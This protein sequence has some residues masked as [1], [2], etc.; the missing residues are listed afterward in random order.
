MNTKSF[1]FY[2]KSIVIVLSFLFLGMTKSLAGVTVS[3]AAPKVC[4]GDYANIN[5]SGC[6]HYYSTPAIPG[7]FSGGSLTVP[8]ITT[9]TY[10]VTG[11]T[12]T[13]AV[14]GTQTFTVTVNQLPNFDLLIGIPALCAGE[15]TTIT[16][17]T[18]GLSYTWAPTTGLSSGTGATVT[19][20]PTTTTTYTATGVIASTGCSYS[21]TI[22]V[23]VDPLPTVNLASTLTNICQYNQATVDFTAS[24]DAALIWN[25]PGAMIVDANTYAFNPTVTTTYTVVPMTSGGCTGTPKTFQVIVNPIINL[26]VSA[27]PGFTT[28]PGEPVTI[29]ATGASS[30][31]WDAS[32]SLNTTTGSSVVA[33]PLT[34]TTYMVHGTGGGCTDDLSV[35]ITVAPTPSFGLSAANTTICSGQNTTI[36]VTG[37]SASSYSWAPS[38]GLNTTNGANVTASPTVTTTYTVTG[39]NTTGCA[40]VNTITINVTPMPSFTLSATSQNICAG[41]SASFTCSNTSLSYTITPTTNTSYNATT[42]TFTVNPSTTTT[43]TINGE[44]ASGC[45]AFYSVFTALVGTGSTLSMSSSPSSAIRCGNNPSSAVI[46]NV[47]GAG[48]GATYTWAPATGLNSTTGNTVFATPASTTTYTVTVT[49]GG[50]T[51]TTT[52]TVIVENSSSV[53]LIVSTSDNNICQGQSTNLAIS[54]TGINSVSWSPSSTLNTST[55]V[56]V[57]ATPTANTTYTASV[58]S[59]AG[60]TYTGDVAISVAPISSISINSSLP[61]TFCSG[62][63]TTLTATGCTS[64]TW[65]PGTGLSSTTG[66]SVIASPSSST[67]Y[68]VTGLNSSGCTVSGTI[69]LTVSPAISITATPSN[70]TLPSGSSTT[71]SASGAI[72]YTWAPSTGL[73]S[74]SG[75]SVIASPT[76]TTIYTVTGSNTS[77]CQ[78]TTTLTVNVTPASVGN[79]VLNP[80]SA[81]NICN[82]TTVTLSASGEANYQW[83][84]RPAGSTGYVTNTFT[85]TPTTTTT[86]T[87]YGETA[88]VWHEAYVTITVN[89]IPGNFVYASSPSICLGTSTNVAT[90]TTATNVTWAPA[91]GLNTT[92]GTSV[93]ASPT[94]TTTYTVTASNSAGCTNVKTITIT[95]LPIPQITSLIT[96]SSVS[97]CAGDGVYQ[98]LSGAANFTYFPTSSVFPLV[99][100][101][102]KKVWLK[103]TVTTTY[104]IYGANATGCPASTTLTVYV[105]ST[106]TLSVSNPINTIVSGNSVAVNPV[107]N[108]AFFVWS[109]T[110]GI[111]NPYAKNVLL[112]PTNTTTYTVFAFDAQGIC[113]QSKTVKVNVTSSK[114]EISDTPTFNYYP[115]PTSEIFNIAFENI[116][117]ES[118]YL[119]EIYGVD[120]KKYFEEKYT[121]GF[122]TTQQLNLSNLAKGTYIV[123]IINKDAVVDNKKFIKI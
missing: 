100:G 58:V 33:T 38:T 82:G 96:G 117:D 113:T 86:F 53:N 74:T 77:G 48:S 39:T 14:C 52:K 16:A 70:V 6:H 8:L 98:E 78:A 50:C 85:V 1:T 101:D 15:S 57:I 59:T 3:P 102:N 72:Y 84:P 80:P 11:Y 27:T 2:S 97:I 60:C 19:A 68:T 17:T 67:T 54:G 122:N 56:N 89:P 55:G 23:Y 94:T 109:P 63:S 79:L 118:E 110:T 71:L 108:G 10:T 4:L 12:S 43:Y 62:M 41:S 105:G 46:L 49:S 83:W 65:S 22:T 35:T 34:T 18:P 61:T 112:N 47:S 120:G 106:P 99:S 81:N 95:V 45:D 88:G 123:R 44:N 114:E 111:N 116:I 104:T 115:N 36:S 31:T 66:G 87:V 26:L 21:K 51:S 28:C 13:G 75:A 24:A 9:T 92:T 32:S 69:A 93:I 42:K 64:C 121:I 37:G 29:N 30:Y 91:T 76:T 73:S 20:H 7:I 40:S 5:V 107:S 90:S 119:V 25:P 103:P